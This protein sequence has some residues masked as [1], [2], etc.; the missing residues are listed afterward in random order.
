MKGLH[1]KWGHEYKNYLR[2][3]KFVEGISNI[4]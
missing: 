2:M 1:D 3:Y 4:K